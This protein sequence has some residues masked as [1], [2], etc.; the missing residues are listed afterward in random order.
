[1]VRIIPFG[2]LIALDVGTLN[3]RPGDFSAE[4]FGR[5]TGLPDG[6]ARVALGYGKPA[7]ICFSSAR[8][9]C[10]KGAQMDLPSAPLCRKTLF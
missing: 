4:V 9:S 10:G 6:Q 2:I 1:M 7:P 8:P 5:Q 3:L